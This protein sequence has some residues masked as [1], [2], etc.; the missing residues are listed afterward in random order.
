LR[1]RYLTTITPSAKRNCAGVAFVGKEIIMIEEIKDKLEE[2]GVRL[3]NL[4]GYL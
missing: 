3:E 2:I 4:R 1:R